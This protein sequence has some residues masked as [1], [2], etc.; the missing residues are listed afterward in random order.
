MSEA[1]L[2]CA[3]AFLSFVGGFCCAIAIWQTRWERRHAE[4]RG[5]RL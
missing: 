1:L 2:V 5:E 4:L 3:I